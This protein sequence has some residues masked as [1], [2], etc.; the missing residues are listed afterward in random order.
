MRET[1][2]EATFVN[3]YRGL[4]ERA[5]RLRLAGL[6]LTD[7]D[8]ALAAGSGV[9]V[10]LGLKLFGLSA[11]WIWNPALTLDPLLWLVVMVGLAYG[12]SLGHLHFPEYELETIIRGFFLPRL[13]SAVA[14]DAKWRRAER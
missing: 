11:V 8:L 9:G 7:A 2:V 5:Y 13:Y 6:R 12:V 14:P 1:D 3:V 4:S 10:M